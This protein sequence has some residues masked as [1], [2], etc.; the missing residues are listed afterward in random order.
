MVEKDSS[1]GTAMA[2]EEID[3]DGKEGSGTSK[4]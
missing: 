3:R 1:Q 4:T 2:C